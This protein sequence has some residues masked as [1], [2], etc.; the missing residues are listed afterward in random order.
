MQS[1]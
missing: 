1:S